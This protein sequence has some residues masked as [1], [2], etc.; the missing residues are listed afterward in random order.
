LV[1]RLYALARDDGRR[2]G[3]GIEIFCRNRVFEEMELTERGQ[4]MMRNGKWDR[5]AFRLFVD[6]KIVW[7][8]EGMLVDGS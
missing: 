6:R 8:G 1:C 2:R 5:V 4:D 3:R 7:L